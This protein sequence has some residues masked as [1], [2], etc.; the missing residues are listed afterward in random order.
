MSQQTDNLKRPLPFGRKF[1][2]E[3]S[4]FIGLNT[5]H[6]CYTIEPIKFTVQKA[7]L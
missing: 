6:Q 5:K 4:N 3:R 1:S 7:M 2:K